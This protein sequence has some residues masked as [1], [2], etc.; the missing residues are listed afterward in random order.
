MDYIRHINPSKSMR[1]KWVI[2]EHNKSFIKNQV[3]D[4][5]TTKS[6]C[7]SRNLRWLAHRLRM[8]ILFY[9]GYPTNGYYFY[10]KAHDDNCTV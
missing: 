9:R 8:D 5:L 10:T 2:D 1:E 3:A 6:I 4:Q 7:I